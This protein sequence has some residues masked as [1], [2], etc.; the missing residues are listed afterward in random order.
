MRIYVVTRKYLIRVAILIVL[1]T[2]AIIGVLSIST[3]ALQ[4]AGEGKDLPIYSVNTN[5]K[6][7]ALTFDCAW[8][9]DDIEQILSTLKKENIKATFFIVG[10][11]AEKY[12]TA[13]KAIANEGHDIANHSYSH[14][15]MGAIDNN[16]IKQEIALCN[17][18]LN[19]ISGKKIEL[20]R[21]PY[22][23]YNN[24]V[25]NITKNLGLYTIQWDV[26]SLD[27]K[28]DIS[29]D[30]ILKRII[31]KIKP[32]SIVLFHN[33][34]VHTANMLPSIIKAIRSEGYGFLPVSEMIFRDNFTIDHEGRQQLEK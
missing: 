28:P 18:K 8:G 25:I 26:D 34:T 9:A 5:E 24:N 32:G 7:L 29:Q 17:S 31:L 16:R 15:R 14:L 11:W 12:P 10:Q 21:A 3:N 4:V 33:D 30:E 23:D 1:L 22:G 2:A 13:V 27:W 6:K 19:T 20:F